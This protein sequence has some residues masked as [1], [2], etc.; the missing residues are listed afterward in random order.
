[1]EPGVS[2]EV[3]ET[4]AVNAQR[5]ARPRILL[6]DQCGTAETSHNDP[7]ATAT[8]DTE[9]PRS[10]GIRAVKSAAAASTSSTK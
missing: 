3:R 4:L 8:H 1:V 10:R 9:Q 2:V 5:E 6:R 7:R